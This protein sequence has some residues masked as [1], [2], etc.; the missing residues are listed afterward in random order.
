MHTL[1][2]EEIYSE[3]KVFLA[4]E[5]EEKNKK[6]ESLLGERE[7]LENEKNEKKKTLFQ[8]DEN[9]ARRKM[10]SPLNTIFYP[11]HGENFQDRKIKHINYRIENLEKQMESIDDESDE[12]K[13]YLNALEILMESAENSD[14]WKANIADGTSNEKIEITQF[15][16]DTLNNLQQFIQAKYGDVEVVCDVA[17]SLKESSLAVNEYIAEVLRNLMEVSI[18]KMNADA[19][20]IYIKNKEK[21]QIEVDILVNKEKIDHCIFSIES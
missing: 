10:F 15:L 14:E 4:K 16:G 2:R 3:L 13:K 5:I 20:L 18:D 11:S 6:R 17:H 8:T 21:I 12:I 9:G 19:F 7:K 1:N